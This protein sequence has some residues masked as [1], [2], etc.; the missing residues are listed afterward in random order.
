VVDAA[1]D[2]EFR[3]PPGAAVRGSYPIVSE[4]PA[5]Q[6][7]YRVTSRGYQPRRRRQWLA[8]MYCARWP[9]WVVTSCS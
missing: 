1:I 3:D 5:R 9:F 8:G 6:R 7:L 2:E 4:D